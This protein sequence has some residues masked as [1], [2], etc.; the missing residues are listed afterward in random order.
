[1][2]PFIIVGLSSAVAIGR[3]APQLT[4][5]GTVSDP[6]TTLNNPTTL[7]RFC[8]IIEKDFHRGYPPLSRTVRPTHRPSESAAVVRV[9]VRPTL[10]DLWV[11][12]SSWAPNPS[13]QLHSSAKSFRMRN[14]SKSPWPVSR[15]H[16]VFFPNVEIPLVLVQ[17]QHRF[18]RHLEGQVMIVSCVSGE[19]EHCEP[20]SLSGYASHTLSASESG[21]RRKHQ[22]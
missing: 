16:K 8:A 6:P 5:K 4:R 14:D 3:C 17:S 2:E 13:Q 12:G 18:F 1:L 7:Y 15:T 9:G 10:A 11:S 19:T 22:Q 20:G 21:G